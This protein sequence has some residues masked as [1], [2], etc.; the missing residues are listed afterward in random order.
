MIW[1]PWCAIQ[2]YARQKELQRDGF[3]SFRQWF[4]Q[5]TSYVQ[6][7][8]F[9]AA[10]PLQ[11]K[12]LIGG[13]EDSK[14]DRDRSAVLFSWRERGARA[15]ASMSDLV[16]TGG[17]EGNPY[18]SVC[19]SWKRREGKSSPPVPSS[20]FME[21]TGGHRDS[22]FLNSDPLE[23]TEE[24]SHFDSQFRPAE[25]DGRELNGVTL[26]RFWWVEHIHGIRWS[27]PLC[28]LYC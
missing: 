25:R 16:P 18:G 2:T 1:F 20:F 8:G 10:S 13:N 4:L 27:F 24:E 11:L 12:L 17:T 15:L 26:S 14:G 19:L 22:L 28:H 7:N 6:S 9:R 5:I 3:P 23:E 21:G